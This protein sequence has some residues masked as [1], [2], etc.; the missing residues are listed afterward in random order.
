MARDRQMEQNRDRNDTSATSSTPRST[1]GESSATSE[2]E[3]GIETSR[4]EGRGR[5]GTVTT[6]AG[7]YSVDALFTRRRYRV[8]PNQDAAPSH[9][10]SQTASTPPSMTSATRRREE[11]KARQADSSK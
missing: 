7:P 4:D 5:S 3:R 1:S 8:G 2:R 11:R 6:G 10:A 9:Q